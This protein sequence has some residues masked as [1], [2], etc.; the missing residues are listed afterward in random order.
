MLFAFTRAL[1]PGATLNDDVFIAVGELALFIALV[2]RW[3]PRYTTAAWT[4]TL[5]G[6]GVSAIAV[7]SAAARQPSADF[8]IPSASLALAGDVT[9]R[10]VVPP[11]LPGSR[12]PAETAVTCA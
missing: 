11:L 4:V 6:L 2:D 7:A 9:L 3:E 12:G 1:A 5:I 8:S 10:I